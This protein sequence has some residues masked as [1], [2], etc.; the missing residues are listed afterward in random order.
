MVDFDELILINEIMK[1]N[2]FLLKVLFVYNSL[3]FLVL[4]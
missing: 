2:I 1:Y 3:V 4:N